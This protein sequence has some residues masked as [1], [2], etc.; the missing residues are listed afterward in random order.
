MKKSKLIELLAAMPGDPDVLFYNGFVDDWQD[1]VLEEADLVKYKPSY[2]KR[3][4]VL[5]GFLKRG[6]PYPDEETIKALMKD[7]KGPRETWGFN[8]YATKETHT[9]KSVV[10]ICGKRKGVTSYDRLGCMEY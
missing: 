8:D 6:E 7:V 3:M 9:M 1:F 4:V 2:T 10:L 5:D